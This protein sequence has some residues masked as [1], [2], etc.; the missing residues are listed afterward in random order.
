MLAST[1]LSQ[2]FVRGSETL[3]EWKSEI[4]TNEW[5]YGRTDLPG[6]V[7]EMLVHLKGYLVSF[8]Y[9]CYLASSHVSDLR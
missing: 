4:I 7:Q 2:R 6:L 9:L 8:V 3:L 5:T 1:I